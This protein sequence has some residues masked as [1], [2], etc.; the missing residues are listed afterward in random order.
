MK[1]MTFTLVYSP[2]FESAQLAI[3]EVP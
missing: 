3:E 2:V 1:R